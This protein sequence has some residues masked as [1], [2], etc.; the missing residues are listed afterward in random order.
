MSH[1]AA[2]QVSGNGWRR[3]RSWI[4]GTAVGAIVAGSLVAV[5]VGAQLASADPWAPSVAISHDAKKG[6]VLAGEDLTVDVAITNENGGK[7]FNAGLTA[8][9][10]DSV[11]LVSSGHFGAPKRFGALSVLP[12]SAR[13]DSND[14]EAQGLIRASSL[15]PP[16]PANRCAVPEGKQ[17]WVF[18][19]VDDLPQGAS[20]SSS[21]VVR[22]NASV[23]PVGTQIDFQAKAY[24]SSDPSRLPV[25]DGSPGKSKSSAHTSGVGVDADAT[26]IPVQAIRVTKSEPSPEDELLR[27]A[28][29]HPTTYTIRIENSGEA[30]TGGV[31]V[32]DYLPAGLEYL[33]VTGGDQSQGGEEYPGSGPIPGAW[34]HTGERVETVEL[35]AAEAEALGLAGAGV[36]TKVTWVLAAPLAGGTPQ[37]FPDTAGTT[38]SFEFTYQAAIPLFE[39]TMWGDPAPDPD[40][41]AQAANLDN[42]T[43]ASTR[44][45]ST[46]AASPEHAQTL[47]NGVV[48]TGRY[49]G[50]V[51][52]GDEALREVSDS[53]TELVEAVD[54]HVVKRV[55]TGAFSVGKLASYGL[56]VRVSEYVDAQDVLLTDTVPNGLCPAFP[57]TGSGSGPKL[58]IRTASGVQDLTSDPAAW[59]A[60]LGDPA[61]AYPSTQPGAS[62]AGADVRSIEYRAAT[63]EFV[64]VF[65]TDA[66]P[67]NGTAGVGYTLFQRA[68]YAGDKGATSSGD[69]LTNTVEIAA[70]TTPVDAIANDPEL[71]EKVG[72]EYFP[73]DDSAATV[74]SDTSELTKTVLKRGVSLAGATAGDW[75]KVSSTPFSAGDRIWYRLQVPFAKGI[76][77]R[78]PI[79]EDYLPEGVEFVSASYAYSGIPG[80]ANVP[81]SA[82]IQRSTGAAFPA[83]LIPA[84]VGTP[85]AD[86]THLAWNLGQR[87]ET[88]STD[89][90]MPE[91]SRIAVF[92]EGRVTGLSA[93]K[94]DV[95]SPANHAK[96]Q[97]VNVDGDVSFL[98]DQA[99]SPLDWGAT[100]KK[101][102]KTNTHDGGSTDRAFGN[103]GTNE[104]VVQGDTVTYRIDV[105]A[106]QNATTDYVIWD[107]LPAGVRAADIVA[108]S[109]TAARYDG[110][111]ETAIQKPGFEVHAYDPGQPMPAGAPA[112][113]ASDRTIVAWKVS[114]AIPG[115]TAAAAGVPAVTR[116][117]TLG[118]TLR[119]PDGAAGGPAAQL[120]QSYENTAAIVS[121]GIP[122]NGTGETSTIVPQR[123]G[124]GGQVITDRTPGDGEFAHPD[125]DTYGSAEV[126]LPGATLDKRLISTEVAPSSDPLNSSVTTGATASRP[127]DAVVPGELATFEYA[128][129]IPAHTTVRGAVLADQGRFAFAGGKSIAYSYVPGSAKFFDETGADITAA[130]S[131]ETSSDRFR[132]AETAGAQHGVLSFP[133]SYDNATNADQ[134]FKARITVFVPKTTNPAVTPVPTKLTNTATFAH[135]KPGAPGE[136]VTIRDTAD[137]HYTAPQPAIRKAITGPSEV[138]PDG[139]VSYTLTASNQTGRPALYDSVLLD[140]VPAEIG[141]DA[142]TLSPSAGTAQLV[143]GETCA[144]V[145]GK[146]V[147]G[148]G[149]GSLIE[150]KIGR[151]DSGSPQTL[152]YTGVVTGTAGGGSSYRNNATLTGYSLPA[153]VDGQS[154]TDRRAEYAVSA[155]ATVT[156][157]NAGIAKSVNKPTAAVG[158]TV[159]YTVKTSFPANANYY[160]VKITDRLPKGVEFVRATGTTVD[161][162][163]LPAAERPSVV[164]AAPQGTVAAGQ[165]LSWTLEPGDVATY[166]KPRS[167]TLTFEARITDAIASNGLLNTALLDWNRVDG[168]DPAPTKTSTATTT[169]QHP[170]VQIS[171]LVNDAAEYRANPGGEFPYSIALTNTGAV[172]AHHTQVTDAVPA[173]IVVDPASISH[174][175]QLSADG[176]TITWENLPVIDPASGSGANKRVV[177]SYTAS[178]ADSASLDPAA[179]AA[180]VGAWLT[181]VAKVD[182]Y[183][184]W[185]SGG[186]VTE[187]G[188]G[189]VPPV[190]SSA[191]AAP[192][193]PRV[194][195]LKEVV[196]DSLAHVGEAFTW[197]LTATNAGAGD[198]HTVTMTDT[199]PPHWEYVDGSAQVSI[200]G[201]AATQIEPAV[202]AS[203][204]TLTWSLAGD[205]GASLLGGTGAN[206][207]LAG[208]TAVITFQAIPTAAAATGASGQLVRVHTNTLG[209]ETTDPTGE[210]VPNFT[211]DDS[212]AEAE[213]AAGDLGIV[214]SRV[215]GADAAPMHA[216]T[217][218]AAWSIVVTNHGPDTAE[219][220]ITVRDT[221][222]ALPAGIV[223]TGAAG[224]GWSCEA[225]SR[226]AN[227]ATT[228]DCARVTAD[229][230]L[231]NGASFPAITVS[232]RIAADQAATTVDNTAKVTPGRTVDLV[233]ENNTSTSTLETDAVADLAIVKSL[234]TAAPNAGAAITW[235][236]TP[237]NLGPSVSAS[238]D[239]KPVTIT[240]RVPAGVSNVTFADATGTW[241]ATAP[242]GGWNAGDTITWRYTGASAP[243]GALPAILLTGTIDA[244]FAGG[245][246]ANTAVIA[247]GE[248]PDPDEENNTS[249]VTTTP[250]NDTA[251]A[252][253]KTRVVLVDGAWVPA[254]ADHR[255]TWGEPVSYRVTVTNLGPAVAHGVTVVDE[256]PAGL[257]GAR[258]VDEHGTWTLTPGGQNAAGESDASWDTFALGGPLLVGSANAGSFIVTYDTDAARPA[259]AGITNWVEATAENAPDP[260]RDP[261]STESN[262]IADLGVVKSHTGDAVAG[263]TLD[264]TIV[265]TNHGPSVADGE[266]VVGD[267][268]PAGFSYVPG[269]A[270]V[271]VADGAAVAAEPTVAGQQ[272]SWTAVADG[273]TLAP[274]ETIVV[275]LTTA[276]DAGVPAQ[277]RLVNTA[278]VGQPYDPSD[279]SKS[280]DPDPSN[281]T[282]EDET[283]VRTSADVTIEKT[284]LGAAG[285]WVAGGQVSYTLTV[286]NAGP[287]EVPTRVTDVLPAGL[288]LASISGAD[289]NCDAVTAGDTAGACEFSANGGSMPV[290]IPSTIDVVANLSASVPEGTELVN[291][292]TVTWVDSDGPG[293]DEDTAAIT[294]T[295]LADLGIEKSVAAP[296]D[297]P[298]V[299]GETAAY[300]L[301]VTNH[302]S[303]DAVAPVTVVDTLPA[304]LT[305][306]ETAWAAG[307]AWDAEVDPADPQRVTFT[308]AGGLGLAAGAE[309]PAIEFGVRLDPALAATSSDADPVVPALVNR[310]AVSSGTTDP[311]PENDEDEAA[312]DVVREV[313]LAIAKSH[314][315]AAVRVG[316]ELPFSLVVT[317]AGPSVATGITVTDTVPAGL[318]VLSAAGDSADGWTI[319]SVTVGE[320]GE[321]V[322]VASRDAAEELAP[323]DALPALT[324]LTRVEPAAYPAVTNVATVTGTEPDR[325]ETNNEA[326]DEVAVPAMVTLVTEK[327]AVGEFKVGERGTYRITVTN[328]GPT[329]DPGPITVTDALPAGLSFA[330]SPDQGVV[331]RGGVV[332]WTL[333]DGL[334]VDEAAILTLV[335]H[336]GQG[337]YPSVTNTV[338]VD[339]PAEKTPES[340]LTDSAT[341]TVVAADPLALTGGD[342]LAFGA[343]LALLALLA[344]A[345]LVLRRRRA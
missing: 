48:A 75:E 257:S 120:T 319:E 323:G 139:R 289:W 43:G 175:G 215:G 194:A 337:A 280:T 330:S 288:T 217:E 12:N 232:V 148:Q 50:A 264:Y 237:S 305:F 107:Q 262:R 115:S 225:P 201:G 222:G 309:A 178:F 277:Q 240:D 67:A 76:D 62:V 180:G 142:A 171:K 238:T 187:P 77:V 182:R 220:P 287:S 199:L 283:D 250:A 279:P 113:T 64:V 137:A 116:G 34:T 324:V 123:P 46:D 270:R 206:G 11:E 256:T 261:D 52:N 8:L 141:V 342:R 133:A 177:L 81:E 272:L 230:S 47:V 23:Y 21:I 14:C 253:A 169:V 207:A 121:Y 79:L 197:R 68:N 9:L 32:V 155:N 57:A 86:P 31:T 93:S 314:D 110:G 310:A 147:R 227:G 185:P 286:L 204:G 97:Q 105:T 276:I 82:P 321:T 74:V 49:E 164:A 3:V 91:S 273:A 83:A 260:V 196:G 249:T 189:G 118:Y 151:I 173:G 328:T 258:H 165:T 87:L 281:N 45:G 297:G 255:V 117:F 111:A 85:A 145:N 69:S 1:S 166:S 25:F 10:P 301:A 221:T 131:A 244:D 78:N 333:E 190:T 37:A 293:S 284:V 252:V 341:V 126:H 70:R 26:P 144:F 84:P 96:Y 158:E 143:P 334:A 331:V 100:L 181:N 298:A 15:T 18:S 72:G 312:I 30:P 306:D 296:A 224:D 170:Q 128:V 216:G 134:T 179:S 19:D 295:A 61:C 33:G 200:S 271:A 44:H 108:G 104:A 218:G 320:S 209:A 268:L 56:D 236:L 213:L 2:L 292:A 163:D 54:I 329:A 35:G 5:G 229:E 129:T 154:T 302:G 24:T 122:S 42:N 340:K 300:R 212:E 80:F 202:D 112:P 186:R 29:D 101:G 285:D 172:A 124:S 66:I 73:A 291:T 55:E 226:A 235:Q 223:V 299:A 311:N 138:G 159:E 58:T 183:E 242:A 40:S 332:T 132:C 135:P 140:C 157:A 13:T 267:L 102:I 246:I 335:V 198:A 304:G 316:D 88:G 174:G 191:K 53:D 259:E 233:P 168:G 282:D 109:E 28:H 228:I 219:G 114:A 339:S 208:G 92:V 203:A 38:G 95:D 36:Y 125:T 231:A 103:G 65:A 243:V 211:G 60:Q 146:V 130:C 59:S 195:L 307:G 343:V 39:N 192:L 22:P 90:F 20:I 176:R 7:Q 156:V 251:L 205:A 274:G 16:G 345:A 247:P 6:F 241:S 152:S 150:W 99:S 338:T 248:T 336:V 322:V 214:K 294:V 265:A 325:D 278:T 245:E 71:A 275:A 188:K 119:V 98:R 167:I 160:D 263:G 94:D 266:I 106:P 27:G 63:G 344:G 210:S 161:W 89:R 308:L 234:N 254:A 4:A 327:R 326:S 269:S 162:A 127:D 317:N 303:S 153:Q 51:A 149:T 41:A 136:T 193:F 313:D 315:P 184:S 290:G 239:A 318:E 17:L